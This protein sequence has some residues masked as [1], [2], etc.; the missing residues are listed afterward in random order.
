MPVPSSFALGEA[1]VAAPNTWGSS[2][3]PAAAPASGGFA[4]QAYGASRYGLAELTSAGLEVGRST[5]R[6]AYG[7]GVQHFAPPGYSLTSLQACARRQ[8]TA[9]L[10]LGLR[11]GILSAN[12]NEYGRERLPHAHLGVQYRINPKLNGG[13]HY[14]YASRVALPLLEHEL[15]VGVDYASSERVHLLA[16]VQQPVGNGL[17]VSVGVRYRAADRL[18]L[19]AGLR[20]AG[21]AFSLGAEIE[22]ARGVRLSLAFSADQRLPLGAAYGVAY[23]RE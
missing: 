21:A 10:S 13:A 23:A 8:L 6:S 20:T 17:G 11:L 15:A 5:G 3:N 9:D 7:L 14:T 1:T 16:S 18:C 2:A 12:Y 22:L 19:N 4:V